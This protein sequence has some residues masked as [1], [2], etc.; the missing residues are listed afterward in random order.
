MKT[1]NEAAAEYAAQERTTRSEHAAFVAG[2]EFANKWISVEDEIPEN[3][4]IVL[5]KTNNGCYATAYF[6]GKKSGFIVYGDDAYY[7]F[8]DVRFWRKIELK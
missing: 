7:D 5:V 4:D 6:H 3:Q 1:V 2:V 8:G